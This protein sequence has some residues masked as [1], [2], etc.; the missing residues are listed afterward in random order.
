MLLSQISFLRMSGSL[1]NKTVKGVVWS[2][3]ERFS[4]AGVNFV[5]GLILARLLMPSDYGAIAML[6]IFMAIAQTFIDSGFSNVLIRKQNRTETDNATAF[7]FNIGVG[8]VAYFLLYLVAP[9]IAQFYNA[10]ILTSL[11]RIM[12]LNLL[13]NSLCVVQQALLTACI[14]FKTQA[15]ISLSAAIVSGLVGIGFAYA[16]YGVWALAIQSVLASIIRTILLW[17]LAKWRPKARFSKQSFHSL[18]GYGSK[19]LASGL[20]DTIYNNLYTIVIGK[21][22][23]AATL[24]VYSRSDQWANFLAVNITGILQR[25][26]FPVLS[27]IQ[28]EDE[29]L[30][31]NY[32]K[33]LRISGFVVFPLMIGLAAVASPLTRFILTDKWVDSIPLIRILCF[34][35]MLY[36]IHAINLN[37]LQV[38]GRSDLFLRLEIYKKIL[39]VATLC[40]TIPMGITAMC[41]GRVF[42]SWVALVMNTYYTGKLIHLGF[43]QQLKD[44][45]PTLLNSFVMGTIVYVVTLVVP[46]SGMQ[47][48]T[49]IV[50]GATYYIVS[51]SL[52]KT[53]EW[54]EIKLIIKR[55]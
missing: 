26:T 37:L 35:L 16:G 15:K 14:D 51:N 10:S 45:M 13:F 24:G 41:A 49:G 47:L 27:T 6:A 40:V 33:F 28:S 2:T 4:V 17:I 48:L 25:V 55:K 32:R 18:F 36:P 54:K 53:M 20:L 22:F 43:F 44:Y 8:L 30:R 23:S 39:G 31:T 3:L 9:Y 1:K 52:F 29:R 50:V 46:G 11:T 12:G 5:F 38:K 19:L 42:T 7:Y 34:A 21:R